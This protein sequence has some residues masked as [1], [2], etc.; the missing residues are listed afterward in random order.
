M[1]SRRLEMSII[2]KILI[3][4]EEDDFTQA[5]KR[6]LESEGCQVVTAGSKNEAE[7]VVNNQKLDM[8]IVGTIRPRGAAFQ[9]HL[10]L[11]ET[12]QFCD[13][14][15]LVIDAPLEERLIRGWLMDEG[16]A[17]QAEDYVSKPIKSDSLVPRI[18]KLLAKAIHMIK[19]L[20]VDDHAVVRE[21]IRALLALQKDMEVIGE[22]ENGKEA[23]DKVREVSPDV[24]LM[25]IVMPEMSGL[26]ATK[27]ISEGSPQTKILML[28][29]YDDKEN[30][31]VAKQ[32][33]AYGFVAKKAASSDLLTGIRTVSTGRYFPRAFAYVTANW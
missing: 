8:V 27:K 16:L 33:G 26:D 23:I 22:A 25:D 28:T 10:W 12:P 18:E 19:V 5:L 29:Q 3:V 21:G 14:P 31:F 2:G 1:G 9:L 32:S 11:K 15:L 17:L 7:D 4:D 13:M 20:V 30:M 24:V 6:S